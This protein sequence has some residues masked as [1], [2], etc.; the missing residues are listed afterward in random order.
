[1]G[2][3]TGEEKCDKEKSL[4][5]KTQVSSGMPMLHEYIIAN[6]ILHAAFSIIMRRKPAHLFPIRNGRSV[7][8][9]DSIYMYILFNRCW[10]KNQN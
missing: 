1:M 4:K 9:F 2:N 3:A 5:I 6:V 7:F 10:P 8:H